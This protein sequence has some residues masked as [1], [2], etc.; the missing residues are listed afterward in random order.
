MSTNQVKPIWQWSYL[1]TASM[2]LVVMVVLTSF[3]EPDA[4]GTPPP[5][6]RP[7]VVLGYNDLGMHCMNQNFNEL[8]ILPP[9]NTLRAQVIDRRGEEPRI[10]TSGV[11]V[12][13]SVPGNTSSVHHTNFW[14]FAPKLFGKKLPPNVGL[15]GNGLAG[16][17]KPTG[18]NDWGATGIPLTPIDDKGHL[19]PYQLSKIDVFVG[20]QIVAT[21]AAVVP[22]S[23]EISCN[24]CHNTPGITPDTDILRK[25]D[26]KHGTKL[27]ASKPVLCA[28]CHADHALGTTGV[29]GVKNLS[30]AMHA[31]H[32]SRMAPVAKLGNA[33]YACHPGQKTNCQ[34][35]VHFA[36]G[37]H[38][39][40]CHGDMKAVGNPAR[41]PWV[42]EPTCASCH[43]KRRPNFQFEEP[44]KL[45]KDSRGHH[46]VH[47]SACHGS[48][49]AITPTVTAPDNVQ[50]IAHQGFAGTIKKCT[51][52]HSQ[53]PE[54][55]FVHRLD[56]NEMEGAARRKAT[57][58]RKAAKAAA[59]S[60]LGTYA[61]A[62][63][64][65]VVQGHVS[66]A[67]N[68]QGTLTT[69]SPTTVLINKV[70]ANGDKSQL[71]VSLGGVLNPSLASQTGTGVAHVGSLTHRFQLAFSR[72]PTG[73]AVTGSSTVVE[74]LGN[75]TRTR[76]VGGGAFTGAK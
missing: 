32:A 18:Q 74:T 50:A 40:S 15:A 13:Y 6:P 44:G 11:A 73:F 25:H 21:T 69:Q 20:G 4:L 68:F 28:K 34:R 33:C 35:D 56:D 46:G 30:N 39:V 1:G 66:H 43:Q 70:H 72:T 23:W 2:A 26:L 24:L 57:A 36:K 58:A 12:R 67:L 76:T 19:N 37:I 17:M 64:D 53:Q 52:C 51:V 8:C 7:F 14:D 65:Q 29:A 59:E 38:C 63:T 71:L 48:P 75:S 42:D 16:Y 62:G 10:V 9:Y 5:T 41:R 60:P 3:P 22:V 45:Y 54:D 27:E 47:C 55:A 61:I 31:S 49:H